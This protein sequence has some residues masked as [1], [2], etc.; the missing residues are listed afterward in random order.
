MENR[1]KLLLIVDDFEAVQ[2]PYR[3]LLSQE[4]CRVAFAINGQEA[5][6]KA[7]ELLPD[8]IFMD[9]S[10]PGIDGWEATRRLKA[11][12]RTHRIPVVMLT[13]FALESDLPEIANA[14]FDGVLSKPCTPQRILAEVDRVLQLRAYG[15]SQ[16]TAPTHL[17]FAL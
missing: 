16:L 3:Y 15:S 7:A 10:L 2:R 9:I 8:V 12:M 1:N 4:G 14:G 17:G 5:V 6:D 13:A 11:D